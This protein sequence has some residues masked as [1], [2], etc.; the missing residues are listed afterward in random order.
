M[1]LPRNVTKTSQDV[2]ISHVP[3]EEVEIPLAEGEHLVSNIF[4]IE[5]TGM[6]AVRPLSAPALLEIRCDIRE[7]VMEKFK[8][9]HLR[10]IQYDP[11]E[12]IWKDVEKIEIF[13]QRYCKFKV[14][15]CLFLFLLQ[16]GRFCK[17]IALV[18][19]IV[20][21]VEND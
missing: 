6:F 17:T 15:S 9:S 3:R 14:E 8:F 4:A 16:Q 12:K 2:H 19:F 13:P 10:M 20:I 21:S 1:T 11:E 18:F 5:T 7:S